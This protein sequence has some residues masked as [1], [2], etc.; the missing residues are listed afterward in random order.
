LRR[1]ARR[2]EWGDYVNERD[3]IH[4]INFFQRLSI[5]NR[6]AVP[7]ALVMFVMGALAMYYFPSTQRRSIQEALSN[8]AQSIAK[9]L[10]LN[11]ATG[12]EFQ[13]QN[14][15]LHA[16][17]G[18]GTDEDLSYIVVR[19]S[20]GKEFAA[21]PKQAERPALP[22]GTVTE[23]SIAQKGDNL[24]VAGPVRNPDGKP[25]GVLQLGMSTKRIAAL[26]RASVLTTFFF[27]ALATALSLGLVFLV[28]R[29]TA[30][31][32]VALASAAEQIAS[33]DMSVLAAEVKLI[34]EGNLTR[35]VRL[36]PRPLPVHT[37]GEVGRMAA[38][39][40]LMLDK[41]AEIATAY[42]TMSS[43]LR[44][45]V[46][47][48]QGAADEVAAGSEAVAGSSGVAVRANESAVAAAESITATLHE[49]NANI[50]NVARNTQSQA[51]TT[52]ETLASIANML[53][54]VETVA[55]AA[56]RL[57]EISTRAS[58]AVSEGS[59]AMSEASRSMADIRD[60]IRTSAGIVEGLGSM[61]EDIGKIV[62]VI[63]EI[64]EQT[65]L[66]AL[67]A[68]IEAARAGE[69]GLGFAVVA[70]EVR[71]LAERSAKST[72]EISELIRGIQTQVAKAVHNME[73]STESVEEGMRR[74]QGLQANLGRIDTS[75]A[76]V[77]RCSEE[78]SHATMEQSSGT[79]EI[80]A[81]TARLAELTQ[82]ISAATE[83]QSTGT[84]QVVQAVE[85]MRGL[86]QKNADNAVGL[87]SSAEQLSGQ[88]G[89]LRKLASRFY[90]GT[91]GNGGGAYRSGQI[92]P[93]FGGNGE[94]SVQRPRSGGPQNGGIEESE[95]V[96]RYPG[97][98]VPAASGAGRTK[99]RFRPS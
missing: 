26:S 96:V 86:V 90:V 89:S 39:F 37:G 32:I 3:K 55:K 58:Q 73:K 84:E 24:E 44:E 98:S 95:P 11:V 19:D 70:E 31:P 99:P 29:Q 65:N 53:R 8:K 23:F 93:A 40:N 66:L 59:T 25:I 1:A 36:N 42:T 72:G 63:D 10:A 14:S 67:N 78:I 16:F 45:L 4:S 5:Q 38:A 69:H 33:E 35:Q 43:G 41:L 71:K 62:G 60:V 48:V 54:S 49:I 46:L 83:E 47:H 12:L 91:E 74:T 20:E 76:E 64:A 2:T 21:F 94:E 52:T 79:Q 27:T 68:A 56:Q 51:A 75:V 6:F 9:I 28:A 18:A 92:A 22:S 7:V 97:R 88:A 30:S 57:V 50:Q 61:A 87:A 34:A 15:V 80:E 85:Q 81:A 82:E 13:D 17:E 77:S